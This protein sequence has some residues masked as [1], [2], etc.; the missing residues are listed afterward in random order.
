MLHR[1]AGCLLRGASSPVRRLFR[2]DPFPPDQPPP[3]LVRVL[4]LG[5]EVPPLAEAARQ[6]IFWT[7]RVLD[8]HHEPM[9][10]DDQSVL[11]ARP[12]RAERRHA[13][14]SEALVEAPPADDDAPSTASR[15]RALRS[16]APR[17]RPGGEPSQLAAAPLM[18]PPLAPP[19]AVGSRS[20]LLFHPDLWPVWRRRCPQLRELLALPLAPT[21]LRCDALTT[22]AIDGFARANQLEPA[23]L[24]DLF[25]S[26]FVPSV[27]RL[28]PLSAWAD[29]VDGLPRRAARVRA[30]FTAAQL[31]A[32]ELILGALAMRML[33]RLEALHT[34]RALTGLGGAAPSCFHLV[35]LAHAMLLTQ[36]PAGAEPVPLL[37]P[38]RLDADRSAAASVSP[39]ELLELGLSFYGVLWTR[40]LLFHARKHH[41]AHEM[42][43]KYNPPHVPQH[44]CLVPGFML[45]LPV[46]GEALRAHVC[47]AQSF[48][49]YVPPGPLGDWRRV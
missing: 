46:L 42:M 16:P 49:Q 12:S 14:P 11:G 31:H 1:L 23:E 40:T 19:D 8:N 45:L 6:S 37:H 34:D 22:R 21:D 3:R 15:R 24:V 10:L 33:V 47:T 27:R 29:C 13:A 28:A 30:Q 18:A 4:L 7:E 38:S 2:V 44:P 25:W 20:P 39:Q 36:D 43:R 35:M 17:A 32:F 41:V 48:P 26:R 9:R 5:L